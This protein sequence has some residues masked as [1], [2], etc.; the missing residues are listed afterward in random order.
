MPKKGL[1]SNVDTAPCVGC[2]LCCDGTIFERERAEAG[3]VGRLKIEGLS[4]IEESGT[5]YFEH[6]CRYANCG[7]CMIYEERFSVCRTFR[8]KLLASYQ[9]GEISREGALEKVQEALAL[10][11]A[12]TDQAPAA[13]EWKKRQ[14]LRSELAVTHARPQLLLRLVALDYYLDRWFRKPKEG[15][16]VEPD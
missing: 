11:S 9:A 16:S 15:K 8:C 1:P 14:T 6:P 5:F 3:E 10:R 2:G 4:V 7:R 12:V 13:G